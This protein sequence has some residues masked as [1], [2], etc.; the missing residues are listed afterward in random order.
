MKIETNEF[1]RIQLKEVFSP[2]VLLTNDNEE[3]TICM[4]DS[5]FEFV[6]DGKRYYAQCGKLEP[7]KEYLDIELTE[8]EA[9][10][11]KMSETMPEAYVKLVDDL[12]VILLK[13]VKK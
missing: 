2:L 12:D 5:G 8:I 11:E 13:A 4:R 6:Y 7:V 9:I 10:S 3:F 1:G